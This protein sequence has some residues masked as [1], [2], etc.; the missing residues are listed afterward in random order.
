MQYN[1]II[2]N[3]EPINQQVANVLASRSGHNIVQEGK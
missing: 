3:D 2:Y 1:E